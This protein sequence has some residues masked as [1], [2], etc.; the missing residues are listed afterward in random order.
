MTSL[1]GLAARGRHNEVID[2]IEKIDES[3]LLKDFGSQS[4]Q[5]TYN[6][7]KKGKSCHKQFS[8]NIG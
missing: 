3:K 5:L 6:Y 4:Y 1:A 8:T 7:S 2:H